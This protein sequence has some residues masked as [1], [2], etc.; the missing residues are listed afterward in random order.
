MLRW[1]KRIARVAGIVL[2]PFLLLLASI[3]VSRPDDP[4]TDFDIQVVLGGNALKRSVV[5]HALWVQH[6]TPILVTGDANSIR[7][8]L[9]R[10]GV[11]AADIIHE[12]NAESTWENAEYSMPIL[13]ERQVKTVVIVTSWFH[14]RRA[15][16]CFQKLEPG[17]RFAT[18]SDVPAESPGFDGWK[19]N[20][21]ERSKRLFYWFDKGLNPW[22]SK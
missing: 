1:I 14:T 15:Y 10:L 22:R 9:L 16:D 8:E 18:K 20:V 19:V 13:R 21:I 12:P 4:L 3:P 7:D 11:P 17:I 5:C 2:L 6:R